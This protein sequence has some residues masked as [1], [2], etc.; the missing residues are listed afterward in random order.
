MAIAGS[1]RGVGCAGRR[2]LESRKMKDSGHWSAFVALPAARTMANMA[3]GIRENWTVIIVLDFFKPLREH[4][5]RTRL[6]P[7]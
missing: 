2:L 7:K 3:L 6:P 4:W 1:V 5:F